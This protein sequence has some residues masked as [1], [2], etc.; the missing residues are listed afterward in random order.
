M[1]SGR[2]PAA[3]PAGLDVREALISVV[4]CTY[5]RS[6]LLRSCLESLVSQSLDK[7]LFDVM[8]VENR[9]TDDTVEL[10]GEFG[11]RC[12]SVRLL[13]EPQPG[14][15]IAR[16]RGIEASQSRYVA[17]IDDDAKASPDWLRLVLEA[18]DAV[19]PTPAAVGGPILPYY[20]TAK[21]DWFLDSYE[22][23]TWGDRARFVDEPAF[24][25]SNMA[26][27]RDVLLAVGGFPTAIGPMG[28]KMALG[29]DSAL[30]K[31]AYEHEPTFYYL[32]EAKVYHYVPEEKMTVRYRLKRAYM[33]GVASLKIEGGRPAL[34]VTGK[35]VISIAFKTAA[36]LVRTPWVR[37]NWQRGFLERAE[38]IAFR[39]GRIA[40][41]FGGV[42]GEEAK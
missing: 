20:L 38:P 23:R 3:G 36:A 34:P 4:I 28:D 32:P 39:L 35:L 7:S 5:N 8:V 25:G 26:F 21:P 40:Q 42:K 31:A 17:F 9:C 22:L 1:T 24:S 6:A 14:A 18:F 30:T 15:G 29:E 27:R 41:T 10:V 12:A 19:K 16:N 33:Q 2:V 37:K 11:R 13:S